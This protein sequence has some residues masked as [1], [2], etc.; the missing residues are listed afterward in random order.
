[1]RKHILRI[2]ILATLL[3]LA[4]AFVYGR[5]VAPR[6]QE[7]EQLERVP[8]PDT[9]VP[10]SA[11]LTTHATSG[12][13]FVGRFYRSSD[14]STRS[15]T[16]PSPD[17]MTVIAI[18]N[19]PQSL[20]YLWRRGE[21]TQQPMQ[22]PPSGWKPQSFPVRATTPVAEKVE[23][24]D[25]VQADSVNSTT[26]FAPA[27]NLFPIVLILKECPAPLPECGERY[28]D[29]RIGEQ[30][31]ELFLPPADVA[32]RVATG[33]VPERVA[34]VRPRDLELARNVINVHATT[35]QSP[36]EPRPSRSHATAFFRILSARC[37]LV[38]VKPFKRAHHKLIRL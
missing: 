23:G 33:D 14:G 35:R 9:W 29:I 2:G 24:F 10:F 15:E 8:I 7:R 4:G 28:S 26:L 13:T 18:K 36:R 27:L 30:P 17:R 22:L 21:W 31:A 3:C 12:K 16:G 19:I 34:V 1:M 38:P 32:Y 20:L 11:K 25:V 6:T 5:T 37:L